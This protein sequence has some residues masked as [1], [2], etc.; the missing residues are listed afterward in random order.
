MRLELSSD[1]TKLAQF[2]IGN[3]SKRKKTYEKCNK[4]CIKYVVMA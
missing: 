4:N 2:A 3:L 1:E